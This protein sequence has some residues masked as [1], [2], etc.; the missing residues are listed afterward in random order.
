MIPVHQLN[1]QIQLTNSID[2]LNS[3]TQLK[4]NSQTQLTQ[5]TYT[6]PT[7]IDTTPTTTHPTNH[8]T[9]SLLV[10]LFCVFIQAPIYFYCRKLLVETNLKIV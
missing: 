6:T 1:A 5:L 7:L 4:H 3:L 2:W 10:L 9:K 8:L